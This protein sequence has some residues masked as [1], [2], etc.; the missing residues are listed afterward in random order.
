M[1]DGV[2]VVVVRSASAQVD[3]ER[4]A[5]AAT[6]EVVV[7]C[8]GGVENNKVGGRGTQC[9]RTAHAIVVAAA[10]DVATVV[11]VFACRSML[12]R[13]TLIADTVPRSR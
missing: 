7:H 11:C 2:V 9:R 3:M 13:R 4:V 6:T 8:G 5:A 12:P 1:V 10:V